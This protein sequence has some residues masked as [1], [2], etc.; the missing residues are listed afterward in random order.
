MPVDLNAC[1]CVLC[2][3]QGDLDRRTQATI[4]KVQEHGWQVVM[5]PPDEHG[6]GWAFTIGLW[7]NYR[8]PELAMFG[9]DI[10]DMQTCLNA[11]GEKAAARL[12]LVAEQEWPD[13]ID[14]YPV[15]LKAVDYHWYRA[16]FGTAIGFYRRPP[17]PFLQ[18]V[19]PGRDGT[20]P[21][22][23]DGDDRY[24]DHQPHLWLRPDEHSPGIWTQDL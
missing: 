12:A 11:L 2:D 6:P 8:S 15:A 1:H 24:R 23:P 19:W 16:F 3:A 7:H 18:V 20:F 4:E 9:L 13:I 17:F 10:Y 5:I 21:W 14:R 22:H